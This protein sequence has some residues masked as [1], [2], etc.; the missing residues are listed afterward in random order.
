MTWHSISYYRF[1]SSLENT[2]DIVKHN[3]VTLIWNS[4]NTGS[5]LIITGRKSVRLNQCVLI[6]RPDS[7]SARCRTPLENN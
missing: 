4:T 3:F 7:G 6:D 5:I 2:D 1:Q